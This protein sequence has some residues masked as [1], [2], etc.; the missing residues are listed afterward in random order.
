MKSTKAWAHLDAGEKK[1][2]R[3]CFLARTRRELVGERSE[4]ILST[5]ATISRL[6]RRLVSDA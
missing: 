6:R 4:D 1:S 5:L 3:S 2:Q